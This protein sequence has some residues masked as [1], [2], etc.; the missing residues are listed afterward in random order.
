MR[1]GPR[2]DYTGSNIIICDGR[3]LPWSNEIRYLGTYIV[4]SRLFKCSFDY[5][6]K[7]FFRSLNAIYGKVG[8][9]ASEE[10]ILV[11]IRSKCIPVLIYGLECFS[12]TKSDLRS[13]DFAVNRFLIKNISIQQFWSN[14]GMSSILSIQPTK[15]TNREKEN[16]I[17]TK[18]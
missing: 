8:R 18:L 9:N 3:K 13:L 16:Q 15:W 17:R 2:N 14:C 10:V 11:L 6:K 1:I 12:L 4:Q 7:S 5:T